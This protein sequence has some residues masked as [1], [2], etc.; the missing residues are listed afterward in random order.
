MPVSDSPPRVA[1]V[2]R[3]YVP[4]PAAASYAL[5]NVARAFRDAGHEVEVLTSTYRDAPRRETAEGITVPVIVEGIIAHAVT[6]GLPLA[7][8]TRQHANGSR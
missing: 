5:V 7:F 3:I 6:I 2:S 8:V 4:E 1:I